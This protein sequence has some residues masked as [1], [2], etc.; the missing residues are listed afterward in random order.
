[1]REVLAEVQNLAGALNL[2]TEMG[3]RFATSGAPDQ[4]ADTKSLLEQFKAQFGSNR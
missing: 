2:S 1:M 4:E 3:G